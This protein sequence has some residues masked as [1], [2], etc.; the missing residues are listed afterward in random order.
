MV[1][2]RQADLLLGKMHMA[3]GLDWKALDPLPALN[4]VLAAKLQAVHLQ[5]LDTG[6][7]C[8]SMHS[9]DALQYTF[10]NSNTSAV[11]LCYA[12]DDQDPYEGSRCLRCLM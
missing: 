1:L 9:D 5:R 2:R 12:R 7:I 3:D 6:Q 10:I 11:R 4:P 8:V